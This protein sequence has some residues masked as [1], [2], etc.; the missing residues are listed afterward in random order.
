MDGTKEEL[1]IIISYILI[2]GVIVSV[3]LEALG[4]FLYYIQGSEAT[5][6]FTS[7]WQLSGRDFFAYAASLIVS[8]ASAPTPI[9]IMALGIVLLMLTPYL[10]VLASTVYF[11]A[12]KD[13]KYALITLYVLVILTLSLTVH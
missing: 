8:F 10:R 9:S 2:A 4:L 7:E 13:L 3:A 1:E 5:S 12:S 11:G 6:A